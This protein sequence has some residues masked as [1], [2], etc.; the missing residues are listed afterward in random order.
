M[1]TQTWL[2]KKTATK[3]LKDL[4]IDHTLDRI[5]PCRMYFLPKLHK[6]PIGMRPICASQGWITYWTS[7]YI[8]LTIFPLLKRI[9]S[10][11]TNSAQLVAMLH[12]INPPEHFQ[13][14]EA[15][16][17]NLY[18]SINIE[19]GLQ[20]LKY[21]LTTT[22]MHHTQVQLLAKLTSWVLT[23][24]YVTF[25]DKKYLQI[26]GTAMGTPCAVVFACIFVHIIE[27]EALDLFASTRF[28]IRCLFL[29]VRFI[30]DLIAIVSDH[31]SGLDLMRLLNSRRKSIHFTFKIR[32]SEAQFLDLTLYKRTVRHTQHLEVKA[33]SKPMNKFLYL[34]PTSC[35]P[36][37]IFGGWIVGCSRRLRQSC[38]MDDDFRLIIDNFAHHVTARGYSNDF[39][40]RAI[41]K[42]PNRATIIENITNP[43][44]RKS[45]VG[46]PFVI[47]YSPEIQEA[48]PAIRQA[49]SLT[50][51]AYLDPH[52]PQIFGC[53]TTPLLSFK[54]GPNLRDLVA[55]SALQTTLHHM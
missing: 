5:K 52:F 18:P 35:H 34:P 49:L 12:K 3:L 1:Y 55:P 11:I 42:I 43:T 48:L 53:R 24:N 17:D 14:I 38:S 44:Q 36:R 40:Q 47:T 13:F 26:S 37:H 27:R 25:G 4:I 50:E 8:H 16:V 30:D 19:E 45:S 22:G 15:D 9:Q 54:R 39:V 46:I 31:D 51:V 41:A 29:F 23:N 2:N 6:N 28:V 33:Y 32:N 21:F 20:A 10:Y 7:V